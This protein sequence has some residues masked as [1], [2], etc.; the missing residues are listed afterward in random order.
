M[1]LRRDGFHRHHSRL[2]FAFNINGENTPTLTLMAGHTYTFDVQTTP[3]FHPFHV[4]GEG[5]VNNNISTGTLTYTVPTNITSSFYNC[6]VHGISMQGNIEIVS[7]PTPQP[8]TITILSLVVDTNLV[9]TSTGT[10]TWSINPEFSTNLNTTNWFAL[11]VQTNRFLNGTN[12]TIC[13]RP[14]G[15][16]VFIP[17]RSQPN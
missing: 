9:L 16:A 4:N 10:N 12:E 3:G 7:P 5:V 14:P 11:T 15:E 6:A 8:P 17:I 13:D 1:G 2:Q